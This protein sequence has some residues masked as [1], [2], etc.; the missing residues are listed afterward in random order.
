M[1]GGVTLACVALVASGLVATALGARVPTAV[2]RAS[3]AFS[4]SSQNI[5]NPERGFYQPAERT[6]DRIDRTALDRMFAAGTRLAYVRIDLG[7]YRAR[8]MPDSFLQALR[9]GFAAARSAGVKLIVRAT[10]NYPRGETEYRSAKDAPLPVVLRHLA[11]MKPLFAANQD[12]I[13]FVQGGFIG[14]WGEWHTSSNNLTTPQA[15]KQV[16]D[17][18][19]AA[20]PDTRFVQ[21]RYPPDLVA[22]LPTLPP[23]DAPPGRVRT[24]FHNDCF[25]AS[26]TDVGTYSEEAGERAQVQA[27][28]A[29]LTAVAP[30]GGETCNPADDPGAVARTDCADILREG[31]RYH[32]TYLNAAYYRRLFHDRWTEQGC[33]DTVTRSMGYRFTLTDAS[34]DKTAAA[35]APWR[36]TLAVRNDGWARLYNPRPLEVVLL[37]RHGG[38]AIR[39]PVPSADPRRWLPGERTELPLTLALPSTVSKGTY[40]VALAM[41]DGSAAL[42][43]DPRYAIRFANADVP[44]RDQRWVPELAAFRTGLSVTVR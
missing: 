43:N 12:V 33:V 32:L 6:L 11:Q 24:G 38:G 8:P 31:A 25:L 28:M 26:Q 22:W 15:R 40:A 5:A 1:K 37:A 10:Y 16:R 17:A 7:P 2:E 13:A 23:S 20:V 18:L 44:E 35:G 34:I 27:H 9:S 42:S 41:P 4:P 3:V 30:F 14:A 19:L 39:L 36:M 21:F 29:A